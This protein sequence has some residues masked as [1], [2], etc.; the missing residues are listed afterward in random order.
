VIA[1]L[2]TGLVLRGMLGGHTAPASTAAMFPEGVPRYY[3]AL[4][5]PAS[6]G[7]DQVQVRETLTGGLIATI[8]PPQGTTFAGI[9][10]AADDRTWVAETQPGTLEGLGTPKSQ[11]L[12]P[13]TWYLIQLAPGSPQPARLS[14]LPIPVTAQ[15]TDVDAISLSPDGAWLAVAYEPAARQADGWPP[16]LS[17]YSIAT[18]MQ[19]RQ[20]ASDFGQHFGAPSRSG[21]DKNLALGWTRDGGALIYGYQPVHEAGPTHSGAAGTGPT[22]EI[23]VLAVR[24]GGADIDLVSKPV[25]VQPC[26]TGTDLNRAGLLGYAITSGSE[27]PAVARM[28]LCT[29]TASQPEALWS[30]ADGKTQLGFLATSVN[31]TPAPSSFGIFRDGSYAPLPLPLAGPEGTRGSLL[32]YIAW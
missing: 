21:P 12:R 5:Q 30:S 2:G 15:G 31:S 13:R 24:S 18:G 16:W 27:L 28:P 17:I 19:T 23:R 26:T 20:W 7:P 32:N 11:R 22:E 1:V 8:H 9:T 6:G 3:A 14:K 29:A 4:T 25:R 10:G